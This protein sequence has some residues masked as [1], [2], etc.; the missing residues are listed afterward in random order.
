MCGSPTGAP[1]SQPRSRGAG[2]A[3]STA[4]RGCS[5]AAM[6]VIR[7]QV[8]AGLDASFEEAQRRSYAAMKVLNSGTHFRRLGGRCRASAASSPISGSPLR[9]AVPQV[10]QRR[11]TAEVAARQACMPKRK[12]PSQPERIPRA[13]RWRGGHRVTAQ[14]RSSPQPPQPFAYFGAGYQSW[15][16]P[17]SDVQIWIWS[18]F[19]ISWDVASSM[20]SPLFSSKKSGQADVPG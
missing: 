13:S 7:H 2:S 15:L 19:P 16:S 11:P 3:P 12:P 6:A 10:P 18:P 17:P 9:A 8:L 4:C 1:G 20:N 5:P 14:C